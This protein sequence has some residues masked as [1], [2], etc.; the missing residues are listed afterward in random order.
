MNEY[1]KTIEQEMLDTEKELNAAMQLVDV[2]TEKVRTLMN[3]YM[4]LVR[5]FHDEAESLGIDI[6]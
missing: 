3:K 4:K 1:L 6:E 2:Q 5:E